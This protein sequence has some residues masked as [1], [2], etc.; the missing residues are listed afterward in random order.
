MSSESKDNNAYEELREENRARNKRKL[1]SLGLTGKD[2]DGEKP[3]KKRPK[4]PPPAESV[5]ESPRDLTRHPDEELR[6][7]EKGTPIYVAKSVLAAEFRQ[8]TKPLHV[9]GARGEAAPRPA[10]VE[11]LA[12]AVARRAIAAGARAA[13]RDSLPVAAAAEDAFEGAPPGAVAL[14]QLAVSAAVEDDNGGGGILRAVEDNGGGGILRAV[15]ENETEEDG[16]SQLENPSPPSESEPIGLNK[17]S[18]THVLRASA[19]PTDPNELLAKVSRAGRLGRAPGKTAAETVAD[20]VAICRASALT[21][22]QRGGRASAAARAARAAIRSANDDAEPEP[23]RYFDVVKAGVPA[24]RVDLCGPS[25]LTLGSDAALADV[26]LEVTD[27]VDSISRIHMTMTFVGG[28]AFVTD[29]QSMRGTFVAPRGTV[30][31]DGFAKIDA[32][33]LLNPGDRVHFGDSSVVY[34]YGCE[35]P[36]A[37]KKRKKPAG[38]PLEVGDRVR[39][40]RLTGARANQN[41]RL[42]EVVR[43]CG[44]V[45]V[46][47]CPATQRYDVKMDSGETLSNVAASSVKKTD[48]PAPEVAPPPPPPPP[49]PAAVSLEVGDR[50]SIK[51]LK[52]AHANQNGRLGEVVRD[53]GVVKVGGSTTQ[54]YDVKMDS[55]E[56]LSNVAATSLAKTSLPAPEVAPP[57]PPP[58]PPQPAAVSLEVGDRVRTSHLKGAR[59]NQN[60]RFGEV[61]RDCGEVAVGGKDATQRYDVKMDSGETLSNVAAHCLKKTDQPAPEV[62]P[63]PPP[64]P[65]PKPAGAHLEVG[66]RVRTSD[67]KG[68]RANQNGRFG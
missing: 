19:H 29:M 21:G 53:C 44:E 15:E 11:S 65:P 36:K 8:A 68:A 42:G 40:S 12:A 32:L 27:E 54:R 3:K 30:G 50:V 66:D 59:A 24:G 20:F 22:S 35:Q 33:T 13:L 60:G 25:Q 37:K 55:G 58:P 5:R 23:A 62:A 64:P 47:W 28:K 7:D 48:Q 34:T 49:Q 1:K 41:Q 39:T 51:N 18:G 52:G 56:T 63:P 46:G 61:V 17:W 26:V 43:D 10:S 57:P 4:K 16:F 2:V 9:G 38:A 6:I 31:E 45:A 67:L 14:D